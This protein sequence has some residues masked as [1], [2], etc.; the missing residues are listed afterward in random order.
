[1]AAPEVKKSAKGTKSKVVEPEVV[2][3]VAA[4]EVKKT[5]KGS[6]AKVVEPEVVE[7]VEVKKATKGSKG[8]KAKV[9]EPEV[10]ALEVEN[11]QGDELVKAGHRYFRCIFKNT[12][13]EIINVGRYSGK[14]PKQAA[15]KA[16][17]GIVKKNSL[18][19]GERVIF[20]I[21][22]C[23]RGSKKKKYSY[24]GSQRNLPEPITVTIRKKDGQKSEIVY[25]KDNEVKKVS[26]SEC[27][28]LLDV[29]MDDDCFHEEVMPVKPRKQTKKVKKTKAKA[30][31]SSKKNVTVD[32]EDDEGGED[33][34]DNDDT[35]VDDDDVVAEEVEVVDEEDV[36]AKEEPKKKKLKSKQ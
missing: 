19:V 13:D 30:P 10:V 15:R 9:V 31:K 1:M 16:L 33:N 22:E 8:S 21:Q 23:T 18:E 7:V 20:L 28:D 24:V 25:T 4:P 26:L 35:V 32:D 6:K 27:G 11:E 12:D 3:E 29:E 5:T 17:T 2:A 14:K 34:E 36:P